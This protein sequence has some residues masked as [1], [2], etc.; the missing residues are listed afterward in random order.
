MSDPAPTSLP[1]RPLP[2]IST[3]VTK[4]F[5]RPAPSA[6]SL[7][8][9]STGHTASRPPKPT[10]IRSWEEQEAAERIKW[11]RQGAD[12][13]PAALDECLDAARNYP[14]N[15]FFAILAVDLLL[16]LKRPNEA[17]E[18]LLEALRRWDSE[19][20]HFAKL[21]RNFH[22]LELQL[23]RDEAAQL[24]DDL[25]LAARIRPVG[26]A[27][28]RETERL[29]GLPEQT[30]TPQWSEIAEQL[31]NSLD[32]G[33]SLQVV[34]PLAKKLVEERGQEELET[35]LDRHLLSRERR[36]EDVSVDEHFLAAYEEMGRIGKA[37]QIAESLI[38]FDARPIFAATVLRL[39]RKLEDYSPAEQ[40]L[41]RHPELLQSRVFNLLYELVYYYEANNDLEKAGSLL[42]LIE[43]RFADS[44]PI[45]TTVRNFYLKYGM[46]NDAQRLDAKLV[47]PGRA[48]FANKAEEVGAETHDYLLHQQQLA[49]L[50]ELTR[51]I[52]HELGQPITNVRYT[53]QFYLEEF[54]REMSKEKVLQVFDVI[55]RQTERMGDLVKRL[56]PLTSNRRI[57]ARFDAAERI[58][59]NIDA[60]HSRFEMRR[61]SV[62]F[63]P[64]KPVWI[65]GDAGHFDQLAS[66]LL[67]NAIDALAEHRPDGGG[68]IKIELREIG[69]SL[70]MTIEDNGPGIPMADRRRIF[71]PFYTTKPPGAGEGLGLFIVWN[72][73]KMQGGTISL[74]SNYQDGARFLVTMRKAPLPTDQIDQ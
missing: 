1:W 14:Q 17:A 47:R 51:G 4:P 9:T 41:R 61:I 38:Q 2:P 6:N 42:S 12:D 49:A 40:L 7:E 32:H 11:L 73:L 16:A 28:R 58:R 27:I 30:A 57:I 65:E 50:T 68:R 72:M 36:R 25:I 15:S 22:R 18:W 53:V 21:A 24:R 5:P 52:S 74:D 70:R 13:L 63:S 62:Q 31:A 69:Q 60:L 35:V 10:Q 26:D 23:S 67:L 3:L 66:N 46:L 59:R 56:S 34:V 20:P 55:L 39:C 33:G 54:K 37:F 8:A 29:L 43:K 48:E 19:N 45:Q 44:Q 64:K 71:N